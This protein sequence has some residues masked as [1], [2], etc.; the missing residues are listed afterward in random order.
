MWEVAA[1]KRRREQADDSILLLVSAG[2]GRRRVEAGG[3][4]C[5]YPVV[6]GTAGYVF[7]HRLNILQRIIILSGSVLLADHSVYSW[8]PQLMLRHLVCIELRLNIWIRKLLNDLEKITAA[9][10]TDTYR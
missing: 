9:L 4:F 2:L 10:P 6:T 5:C 1:S 7:G 8:C 3:V